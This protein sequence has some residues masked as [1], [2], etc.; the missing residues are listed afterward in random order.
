MVERGRRVTTLLSDPVIGQ[1]FADHDRFRAAMERLSRLLHGK[2]P[3][4]DEFV[5]TTI[6]IAAMSG[7]LMHPF[8]ASVDDAVLRSHLLRLARGY[9]GLEEPLG[10]APV[11]AS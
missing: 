1:L 5:Q 9:L 11:N 3:S 7:A 4:R 6:L 2:K 10:P 8:S